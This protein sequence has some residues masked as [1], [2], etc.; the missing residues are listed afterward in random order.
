MKV[1]GVLDLLSHGVLLNKM[2]SSYN[3]DGASMG[4]PGLTGIAGL[5]RSHCGL[6]SVVFTKSVGIHMR[7]NSL[8]VGEL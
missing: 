6:S 8:V 2:S 1:V 7:Q 5:L 4:K 3:V